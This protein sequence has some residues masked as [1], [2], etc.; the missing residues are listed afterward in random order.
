MK[1]YQPQPVRWSVLL[2]SLVINVVLIGSVLALFAPAGDAA[3][4]ESA[5]VASPAASKVTSARAAHADALAQQYA[6]ANTA[7]VMTLQ[8]KPSKL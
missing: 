8:T 5:W 4:L 7:A 1:A 3:Q 6:A 2:S